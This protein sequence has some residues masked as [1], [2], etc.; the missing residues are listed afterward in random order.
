MY[1]QLLNT[2][3]WSRSAQ[4]CVVAK[5]KFWILDTFDPKLGQKLGFPTWGQTYALYPGNFLKPKRSL[6]TWTPPRWG[7]WGLWST[8][9]KEDFGCDLREIRKI[10]DLSRFWY[11]FREIRFRSAAGGK[12]WDGDPFRNAFLT[13]KIFKCGAKLTL[14]SLYL[15]HLC[16]KIFAGGA[17]SSSFP[18]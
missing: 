11:G 5:S 15:S 7:R 9:N 1:W 4:D 12:F 3:N 17:K 2:T 10:R 14:F 18:L 6:K 16:T 13:L 8:G